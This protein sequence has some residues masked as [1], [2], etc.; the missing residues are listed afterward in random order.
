LIY[1]EPEAGQ[2]VVEISL[3]KLDYTIVFGERI[4]EISWPDFLLRVDAVV[5]N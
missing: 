3:R 5:E 1:Q 4:E 2:R